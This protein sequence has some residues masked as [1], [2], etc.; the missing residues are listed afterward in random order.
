[1]HWNKNKSM[2]RTEQTTPMETSMKIKK[3]VPENY[4]T[5]IRQCIASIWPQQHLPF[6]AFTYS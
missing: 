3:L 5:D 4:S 1:M 6:F 2:V